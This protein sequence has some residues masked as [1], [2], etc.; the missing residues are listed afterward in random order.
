LNPQ[1]FPFSLES[2][3]FNEFSRQR[4]AATDTLRWG[5]AFHSFFNL[6]RMNVSGVD[7]GVKD[8][9]D[10]LYYEPN[11]AVARQIVTTLFQLT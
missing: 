1:T 10:K 6:Q 2:A 3:K 5:Q 7:Q 8:L 9:L 11:E 4:A